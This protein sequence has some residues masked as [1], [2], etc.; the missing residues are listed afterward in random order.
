MSICSDGNEMVEVYDQAIDTP[1]SPQTWG[2]YVFRTTYQNGDLWNE[3][4]AYIRNQAS[5]YLRTERHGSEL[6]SHL[7]FTIV[8]DAPL[9]DGASKEEVADIFAKMVED[10]PK[11]GDPANGIPS[12]KEREHIPRYTHCIYVD[13]NCLESYSQLDW[14]KV[15]HIHR[16]LKIDVGER[17]NSF[18]PDPFVIVLDCIDYDQQHLSRYPEDDEDGALE[19]DEVVDMSWMP[20][21]CR[22]LVEFYAKLV[23]DWSDYWVDGWHYCNP[24]FDTEEGEPM[25]PWHAEPSMA[26]AD[27]M[28]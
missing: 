10:L 4:I 1:S 21:E 20:V 28:L 14:D 19:E 9:L 24:G 25:R 13:L 5:M 18:G 26:D 22:W 16:V 23:A 2:F 7:D 3:Y 8:D 11:E 15:A 17:F 6:M 27:F 12:A